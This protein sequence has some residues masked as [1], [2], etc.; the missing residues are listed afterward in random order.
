MQ[1]SYDAVSKL[2][3]EQQPSIVINCIGIIKQLPISKIPVPTIAINSL[4]PHQLAEICL[5][6]NARLIHISTDCVFSGRKGQV[7]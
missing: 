5:S 3:I 7:Q 6:I 2:I 1:Q 4:F